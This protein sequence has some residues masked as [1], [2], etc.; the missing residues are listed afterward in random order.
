[1]FALSLGE[2]LHKTLAEI[3]ELDNEEILLWSAYFTL[4]AKKDGNSRHG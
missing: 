3:M 1:M 2:T 4:K